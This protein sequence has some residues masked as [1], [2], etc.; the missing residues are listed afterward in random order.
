MASSILSI[1]NI[2]LSVLLVI[3]VLLQ[4]RGSGLGSAFGGSGSVYTT[5]RGAD[6]FLFQATIAIAIAFFVVS[7]ANLF[8]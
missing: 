1:L 3:V 2:I 5:K 4:Q 6:R 7:F 8:V